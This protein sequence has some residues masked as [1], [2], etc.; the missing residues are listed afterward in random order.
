MEGGLNEELLQA[1]ADTTGGQYY[2]AKDSKTLDAIFN[3]INRL[4]KTGFEQDHFRRYTDFAFIFIKIGLA[5]LL[6][7]IF[8]TLLLRADSVNGLLKTDIEQ[9]DYNIGQP[10]I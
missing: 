10:G 7:G 4:E 9:E 2:R 3:N 5:M 1:I 6:A 8:S